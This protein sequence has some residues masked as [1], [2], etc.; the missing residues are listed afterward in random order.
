MR[1]SDARGICGVGTDLLGADL[2]QSYEYGV[3]GS[4][5]GTYVA[6]A[7]QVR[8]PRQDMPKYS[9]QFLSEQDMADIYA[10]VRSIPAPSAAWVC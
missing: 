5:P 7:A 10:F 8:T 9:P 4:M 2:T 1:R 3:Q 6:F